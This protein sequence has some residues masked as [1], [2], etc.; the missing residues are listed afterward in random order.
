M[1]HVDKLPKRTN[2][3]EYFNQQFGGIDWSNKKILD[4]GGDTGGFLVGAKG[5][6]QP[7]NYCCADVS[8]V[9]V[10]IGKQQH[11]EANFVHFNRYSCYD[12]PTGEVG[13][14]VPFLPQSF[15]IIISFSVFTHVSKPDMLSLVQQLVGLL[16]PNGILGFTFGDPAYTAS[17]DPNWDQTTVRPDF[18]KG[19]TLELPLRRWRPSDAKALLETAKGCRWCTLVNDDFRIEPPDDRSPI[20][21]EGAEFLQW[22]DSGYIQTLFPNGEIKQPIAPS[23]QHCVVIRKK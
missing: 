1:A 11:P 21:K 9:A 7:K 3:I 20:E 10:E 23:T 17:K 13:L 12:N 15:D 18:F 4:F 2:Q 6:V 5:I 14:A 22:Y 8:P 19:N 16:K